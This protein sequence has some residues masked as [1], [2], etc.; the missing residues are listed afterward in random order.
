MRGAP[1]PIHASFFVIGQTLQ[2]ELAMTGNARLGRSLAPS[3]RIEI[4]AS[5]AGHT[6]AEYWPTGPEVLSSGEVAAVLTK[7]LGRPIAYHQ[8]SFEEQKQ[9]MINADL[10]KPSPTT[11]RAPSR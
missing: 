11:T 4:A 9:A 2:I 10:L 7:V 3:A 6:T 1:S 8:I 5:P